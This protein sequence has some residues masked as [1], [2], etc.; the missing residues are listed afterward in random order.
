MKL[1]PPIVLYIMQT[2]V[3]GFRKIV[4]YHRWIQRL[5]IILA[6]LLIVL[7]FLAMVQQRRGSK[8]Q[9]HHVQQ[10]KHITMSTGS[11]PNAHTDTSVYSRYTAVVLSTVLAN[12]QSCTNKNW[13]FI[14]LLLS[15]LLLFYASSISLAILQLKKKTSTLKYMDKIHYIWSH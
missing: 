8:M 10:P 13:V 4:R 15:Q 12:E 9:C 14:L 1:H 2:L 7:A 6:L 3:D 5:G 11:I